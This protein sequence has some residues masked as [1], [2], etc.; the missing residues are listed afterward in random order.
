MQMKLKSLLEMALTF[1]IFHL[2]YTDFQLNLLVYFFLFLIISH[3]VLNNNLQMNY[4]F[5]MFKYNHMLIIYEI[6]QMDFIL[7]ILLKFIEIVENI[8]H[9]KMKG[10]NL[11]YPFY[12]QICLNYNKIQFYLRLKVLKLPFLYKIPLLYKDQ[13]QASI[14]F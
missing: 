12:I 1:F 7:D 3:V 8:I 10:Q 13:N 5:L 14:T 11:F 9:Q 4:F 2:I 6:F